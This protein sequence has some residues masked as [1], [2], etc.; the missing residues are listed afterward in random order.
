DVGAREAISNHSKESLLYQVG[1][2]DEVV[3]RDPAI[4]PAEQPLHQS[5]SVQEF[6]VVSERAESPHQGHAVGRRGEGLPQGLPQL[7]I[8]T[9]GHQRMNIANDDVTARASGGV[10]YGTNDTVGRVE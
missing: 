6:G 3:S 2:T 5:L 9:G 4:H 10:G 1:T 8:S 7:R